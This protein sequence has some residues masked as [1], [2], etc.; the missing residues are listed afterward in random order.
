MFEA[1]LVHVLIRPSSAQGSLPEDCCAKIA[2]GLPKA[3]F[4]TK[5]ER[6]LGCGI[7][8]KPVRTCRKWLILRYANHIGDCNT[9][10]ERLLE[11]VTTKE[12]LNWRKF[13]RNDINYW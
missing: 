8:N 7:E 5:T 6:I 3:V 9:L 1:V 11:S 2:N 12:D 13:C 10:T 4:A